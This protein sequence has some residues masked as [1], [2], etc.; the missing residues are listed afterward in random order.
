MSSARSAIALPVTIICSQLRTKPCG[1][2]ISS[3]DRVPA[4]NDDDTRELP[5][6]ETCLLDTD[7]KV[8]DAHVD[9]DDTRRMEPG[10]L[11]ALLRDLQGQQSAP[12]GC[13]CSLR[14]NAAGF[15]ATGTGH[16]DAVRNCQPR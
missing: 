1:H 14:E 11:V 9:K 13:G 7:G 16:A 12:D 3:G 10:K 5:V 4:A 2:G 8:L 6:P 15:T